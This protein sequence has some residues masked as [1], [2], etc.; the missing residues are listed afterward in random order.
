MGEKEMAL[1]DGSMELFG[2]DRLYAK[3]FTCVLAEEAMLWFRYGHM[4]LSRYVLLSI[5]L[6]RGSAD[7]RIVF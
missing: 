4:Y 5:R 7:R 6:H 3:G 1:M 2:S